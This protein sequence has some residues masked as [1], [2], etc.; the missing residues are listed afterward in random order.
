MRVSADDSYWRDRPVL[1][2]GGTGFA[3]G[4]LVGRLV[5][6]G[7]QVVSVVRD[8]VPES[9]LLGSG[10]PQHVTLVFGDIRDQALLERALGDYEIEIV[11]HLAAQTIVSI[12]N[13]NP[14]ETLDTNIRGTSSLLE[15]CRR[16]PRFAAAV[17]RR[18]AALPDSSLRRQQGVRRSDRPQ[19]RGD[20]RPSGR[21][22][23]RGERLRRW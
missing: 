5:E 12:A 17:P 11:F 7:A 19:L 4:W 3:G 1:V 15:A 13:R 21:S 10:M 20:L 2:T 22:Y 9:V 14:V 16:S 18:S 6:L 8:W 23:S